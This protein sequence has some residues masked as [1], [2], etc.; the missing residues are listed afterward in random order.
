MSGGRSLLLKG[1]MRAPEV[2]WQGI[3]GSRVDVVGGGADR[4]LSRCGVYV[5]DVVRGQRH[6]DGRGV[7]VP[8]VKQL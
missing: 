7:S 8:A 2:P 3:A 5:N 1:D 6:V 4:G